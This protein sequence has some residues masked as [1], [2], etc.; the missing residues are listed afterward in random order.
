MGIQYFLRN[1]LAIGLE[2][3]VHMSSAKLYRPN[4][5]LNGVAGLVAMNYYF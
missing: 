1:N 2:G 3:T 5:G 4:L